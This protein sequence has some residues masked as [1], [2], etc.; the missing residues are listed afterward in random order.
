MPEL[1]NQFHNIISKKDPQHAMKVYM[2]HHIISLRDSLEAIGK[3]VR[4]EF[5]NQVSAYIFLSQNTKV[6][7]DTM[8][9]LVGVQY[10][11]KSK[12]LALSVTQ[13]I[14]SD[15]THGGRKFFNR[16]FVRPLDFTLPMRSNRTNK[17]TNQINAIKSWDANA[18]LGEKIFG[19]ILIGDA[20]HRLLSSSKLK[21]ICQSAKKQYGDNIYAK[22]AYRLVKWDTRK[23]RAKISFILS[24][25]SLSVSTKT[26]GH[27]ASHTY[28][29]ISARINK[30][31]NHN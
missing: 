22:A 31:F 21:T 12:A 16:V 29:S 24:I 6:V 1:S 10:Y 25:G 28:Q 9:V 14:N 4:G 18:K 23:I 13:Q 3:Y 27:F 7:D 26:L 5:L 19:A 17:E 8:F 15:W 11:K 30:H 2:F 20:A